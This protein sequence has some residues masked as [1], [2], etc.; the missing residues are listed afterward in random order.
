MLPL[1]TLR[2]KALNRKVPK[3]KPQRTQR[4]IDI[5]I[6]VEESERDRDCD[7][8]AGVRAVIHVVP[9]VG[10]VDIDIVSLIPVRSP[11]FRPGVDERDPV[12]VVLEARIPADE[13]QRK[14]ADVEKV[15]MPEVEPEAVIGNP[16]AV[17][18]AALTPGAMFVMPRAGPG[19]NETFVYL[20]LVLWDAAMVD[21]TMR[22]T[23]GLDTAVIGAAI[24]LLRSRRRSGG[25]VWRWCGPFLM[26]LLRGSRLLM[27]LLRG[28]ALLSLLVFVLRVGRS[29]CRKQQ[30]QGTG[31]TS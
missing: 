1:R 22:G 17:V 15:L 24:A 20:P 12:A 21:A 25:L 29:N 7:P 16:V 4:K 31:A 2:S 18:P 9:I 27:L 11:V 28:F 6:S 10:V 5:A 23:I 26:R 14:L 30:E 8:L 3:E 19:V 13:D